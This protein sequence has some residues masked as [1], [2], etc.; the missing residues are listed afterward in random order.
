VLG[1]NLAQPRPAD[2]RSEMRPQEEYYRHLFHSIAEDIDKNS[3]EKFSN[4]DQLPEVSLPDTSY[5]YEAGGFS[6]FQAWL[7]SD[8]AKSPSNRMHIKINHKVG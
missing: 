3:D 7:E 2:V 6:D 4:L 8:Q 1:E 5:E